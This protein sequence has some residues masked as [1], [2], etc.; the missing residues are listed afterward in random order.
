MIA[1]IDTDLHRLELHDL[2]RPFRLH[3]MEFKCA[4]VGQAV[5]AVRRL[6]VVD[7]ASISVRGVPMGRFLRAC[8]ND[9]AA[10]SYAISSLWRITKS[11]PILDAK[12]LTITRIVSEGAP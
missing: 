4:V 8:C 5:R 2:R 3:S 9:R 10:S 11:A 7:Y 12:K 6:R 1:V